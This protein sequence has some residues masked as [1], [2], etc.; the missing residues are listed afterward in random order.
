MPSRTTAHGCVCYC[1]TMTFYKVRYYYLKKKKLYS[2]LTQQ[3]YRAREHQLCQQPNATIVPKHR[4]G[5][6]S[7]TFLFSLAWK[8]VSFVIL[9]CNAKFHKSWQKRLPWSFFIM[10]LSIC[11]EFDNPVVETLGK[12][13]WFS[14][15]ESRFNY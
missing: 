7:L 5:L 12:Y 8:V 14:N 6:Y 3:P 15:L 10:T 9:N 1:W 11:R 2:I 13:F 4:L